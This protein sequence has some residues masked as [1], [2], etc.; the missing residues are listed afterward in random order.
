MNKYTVN[1]CRTA[2]GWRDIEVEAANKQEAQE[3][4]VDAAGDFEFSMQTSEYT[5][6][7]WIEHPRTPVTIAHDKSDLGIRE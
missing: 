4:A 3:K 2:F 1:I 5:V 6:E 7:G